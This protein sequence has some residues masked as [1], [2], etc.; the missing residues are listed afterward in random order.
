M[1]GVTAGIIQ[2]VFHFKFFF[3]DKFYSLKAHSDYFTVLIYI[4]TRIAA[5]VG[6]FTHFTSTNL[7]NY[8]KHQLSICILYTDP[9]LLFMST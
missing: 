9:Q 3:Q 1:M 4:T 5:K 6:I 7:P 2:A 8:V